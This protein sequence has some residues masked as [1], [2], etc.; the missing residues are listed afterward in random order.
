MLF[1]PLGR[2]MLKRFPTLIICISGLLLF[3]AHADESLPSSMRVIIPAELARTIIQNSLG[4]P[5]R[6]GDANV[7]IRNKKEIKALAKVRL[8]KVSE[9]LKVYSSELFGI[10]SSNSFDLDIRVKDFTANGD[11]RVTSVRFSE[12]PKED[13]R[14]WI[15]TKLQLRH[16]KVTARD[17]WLR[18]IGLTPTAKDPNSAKK[19]GCGVPQNA[20]NR[21]AGGHL[22]VSVQNAAIRE[23]SFT[24]GEV[25]IEVSARFQAEYVTNRKTNAKELV[26]LPE[27][28]THTVSDI[29]NRYYQLHA[30]LQVPPIFVKINGACYK[31]DSSGVTELFNGFKNN[32][33]TILAEG[34]H[35]E[36]TKIALR[37]S[38]KAL[39]AL[40]VPVEKELKYQSSERILLPIVTP[41][42][43]AD[44]TAV[45][46]P[47]AVVE[48]RHPLT[49]ETLAPVKK[50]S[51]LHAILWNIQEKLALSTIQAD[52]NGALLLSLQDALLVN[53]RTEAKTPTLPEGKFPTQSPNQMRVIFNRTF[54]E[55]KV[56]LVSSLRAEQSVL[57]PVG[58]RLGTKG[59][60]IHS[61]DGNRL[62]ITAPMEI[63]LHEMPG[64]K[65]V[66]AS[67]IEKFAGN[68]DGIY[69][70]P[71]QIDLTP[72]IIEAPERV[73]RLRVTLFHNLLEN[74]FSQKSNL[75]DGAKVIVKIVERKVQ[76]AARKLSEHPIDVPLALLESKAPL[77]L[78]RIV[79]SERGSLAIDLQILGFRD[80]LQ[81]KRKAKLEAET[82]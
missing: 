57:L 46:R 82:P 41:L 51:I 35:K 72:E 43:P 75:S 32:I 74:E 34:L 70:I 47:I 7:T 39:A 3:S 2:S 28:V 8:K 78:D 12:P 13:G 44:Q 18:E 37:E 27:T 16:V 49:S 66:A 55:S 25:P 52:G 68:T 22:A 36:L 71:F 20:L 33:K 4:T 64:I 69:R 5:G 53:G 73:L 67:L 80:I 1:L 9:S 65:G 62:S 77:K 17:V 30:D 76:E 10:S 61:R 19:E 15:D 60:D 31:G 81:T 40:N 63:S 24:A 45:A 48:S 26:L 29:I 11:V 38:A 42:M 21:F 79:F 14:I 6:A 54:F 50:T 23:N 56:D 59:L 58:V